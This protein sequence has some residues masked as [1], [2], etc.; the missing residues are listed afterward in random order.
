MHWDGWVGL[1]SRTDLP[2]TNL[3]VCKLHGLFNQERKTITGSMHLLM[4]EYAVCSLAGMCFPL[5]RQSSVYSGSLEVLYLDCS[6][7]GFSVHL[8]R[9]K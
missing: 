8:P 5:K 2:G 6:L 9:Q 7:W 1:A 4:I 3:S